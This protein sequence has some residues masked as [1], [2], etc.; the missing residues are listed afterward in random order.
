MSGVLWL[1]I[2]MALTAATRREVVVQQ[3]D[4]TQRLEY[5]IDHPQI[6]PSIHSKPGFHICRNNQYYGSFRPSRRFS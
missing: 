2:N 1:L 5:H 4:Q 3:L 6:H